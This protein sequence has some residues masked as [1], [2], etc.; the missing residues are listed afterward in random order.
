MVRHID[1]KLM[2]QNNYIAY[3]YNSWGADNIP[4]KEML[5]HTPHVD[6]YT[7]ALR[8]AGDWCVYVTSPLDRNSYHTPPQGTCTLPSNLQI[9]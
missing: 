1:L 8:D 6:I 3:V 2:F 9:I 5:P 4:D 7:A